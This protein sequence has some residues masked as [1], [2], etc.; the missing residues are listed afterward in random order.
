MQS[1]DVITAYWERD[2]SKCFISS[3][4]TTLKQHELQHLRRR[5][6]MYFGT[7]LRVVYESSNVSYLPCHQLLQ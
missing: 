4:F 2:I 5:V 1:I 6:N 7:E 3:F